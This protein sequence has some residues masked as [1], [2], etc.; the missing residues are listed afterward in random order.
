MVAL[1]VLVISLVLLRGAGQFG[2]R[3]LASWRQSGLLA[4]A[5]MFVFTGT[6]HFTGMR[7]DYAA[8]LPDA[9]P[10][11]LPLIYLA[12]ALQLAGA[13]G[14][15]IPRTRRLAGIC[16]ALL[17]IAMFP[18]NVYAALRGIEFRGEP[19]A[20]LWLRT[21]TQ[22]VFIGVVWW[23]AVKGYPGQVARTTGQRPLART[24]QS[25]PMEAPSRT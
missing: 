19:P 8:M 24:E 21:P 23:T 18:G 9:M 17:L 25:S 7:H 12:G 14:L 20:P 6:S 5:I 2:L 11:R 22:L 15:L 13:L 10:L 4:A 3:R 1:L 16:L